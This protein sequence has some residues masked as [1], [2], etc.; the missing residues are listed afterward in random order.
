MRWA[1]RRIGNGRGRCGRRSRGGCPEHYL[2]GDWLWLPAR[3]IAPRVVDALR[4]LG[5]DI[6]WLQG[7]NFDG[8][9]IHPDFRAFYSLGVRLES[10]REE[11][12]SDAANA[13]RMLAEIERIPDPPAFIELAT[14]FEDDAES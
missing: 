11:V 3:E 4:E 12:E 7:F 1:S 2:Q 8:E 6:L 13:L 10:F 9:Q 5:V 14:V